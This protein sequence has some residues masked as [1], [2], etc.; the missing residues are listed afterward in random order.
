MVKYILKL[1]YNCGDKIIFAVQRKEKDVALMLF[2][3]CRRKGELFRD[4]PFLY[5]NYYASEEEWDDD[6]NLIVAS[7]YYLVKEKDSL[8]DDLEYLAES[9]VEYKPAVDHKLQFFNN[10]AVKKS[11]CKRREKGM[12]QYINLLLS[13]CEKKEK[14][15][16]SDDDFNHITQPSKNKSAE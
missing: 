15:S 4:F 5:P 16:L 10:A 11:F 1:E 6:R 7:I 12:Q 9:M 3:D 13:L 14:V 8:R 2:E